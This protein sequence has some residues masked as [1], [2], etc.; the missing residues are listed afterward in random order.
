MTADD[1]LTYTRYDLPFGYRLSDT[2]SR[3][4]YLYRAANSGDGDNPWVYSYKRLGDIVW[5][6]DTSD[7]NIATVYANDHGKTVLDALV[8]GTSD[9]YR[10]HIPED[11][12]GNGADLYADLEEDL[13]KALFET[14]EQETG[15]KIT[16][17]LYALV[18]KTDRIEILA[19][20]SYGVI[21]T[22]KGMV[23]E[24][25]DGRYGY[26]HYPS[27]DSTY[28]TADG[29]LSALGH[30]TVEL[31]VLDTELALDV[32]NAAESAKTVYPSISYEWQDMEDEQIDG[33][34]EEDAEDAFWVAWVMLGY[35]V[36]IAPLTVGLV[37]ARS[38]KMSHPK[39]WYALVGLAV[40]WLITAI[41]IT[42][43]LVV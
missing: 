29:Y 6:K 33:G 14:G 10:L 16:C 35:L 9:E 26:L 31:W 38:S 28:F 4:D 1:R 34:Y 42:V 24:L 5:L 17:S 37:F 32:L 23:Y 30:D 18:Y 21:C 41:L 22:T 40:A 39:R 25:E 7:S 3:Y 13:A 20:D 12:G 2:T 15:E 27:L 43:L 19:Y 8:K 11:F 36:P